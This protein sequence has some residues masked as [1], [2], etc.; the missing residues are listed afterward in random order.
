MLEEDQEEPFKIHPAGRRPHRRH[1][2]PGRFRPGRFRPNIYPVYNRPIYTQP[3]YTEPTSDYTNCVFTS[4]KC[5]DAFTNEY[6]KQFNP[7]ICNQIRV[8]QFAKSLDNDCL[9]YTKENYSC[10]NNIKVNGNWSTG[11]L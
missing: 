4:G 1:F 7:E 3:V 10:T 2:R 8:Q 6:G 9:P 11:V 5:T